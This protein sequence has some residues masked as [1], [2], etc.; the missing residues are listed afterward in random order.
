MSPILNQCNSHSRWLI[1][2]F[3]KLAFEYEG[4]D[5]AIV[6]GEQGIENLG[7][8]Y[9]ENLKNDDESIDTAQVL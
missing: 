5:K 3:R 2:H 7:D 1:N 6:R 9:L 8:V 4:I